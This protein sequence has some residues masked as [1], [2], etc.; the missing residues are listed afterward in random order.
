MKI[1]DKLN[2]RYACKNLNVEVRDIDEKE[3]IVSGYFASF[4]TIDSDNDVI[5][6]GAFK[7]S[8]QERGPL[9]SGN[10]RTGIR[11]SFYGHGPGNSY[12]Y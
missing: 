4:D 12:S 5:R 1:E 6:K 11:S 9:S 10:R 3:G 8:I 2:I 7:K